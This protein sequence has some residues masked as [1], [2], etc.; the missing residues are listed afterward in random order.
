VLLAGVP[1]MDPADGDPVARFVRLVDT[2]YDRNVN[3]I[4]SAAAPPAGLYPRG[5]L[6]FEFRRTRSRLVE[7][8]SREYLSR[9]HLA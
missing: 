6:E 8:Q 1:R 9:E 3:L 5:R 7:M 2:L 4:V